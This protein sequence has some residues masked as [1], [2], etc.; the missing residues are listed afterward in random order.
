MDAVLVLRFDE[1]LRQLGSHA[2]VEDPLIRGAAIQQLVIGDDFR[3]GSD[4][5]GDFALLQR[6]APHGFF[7]LERAPT[8][9]YSAQRISSTL[10]RQCLQDGA[11]ATAGL[12]LKAHPPAGWAEAAAPVV[13]RLEG[14]RRR[15]RLA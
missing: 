15:C 2:F 4:R 6:Y 13:S 5:S 7:T 11:L 10:I 14:L 3:C 1:Q 9:R 8:L 12:L